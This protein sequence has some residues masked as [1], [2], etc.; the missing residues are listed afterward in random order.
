MP[1][2]EVGA[3]WPFVAGG[4]RFSQLPKHLNKNVDSIAGRISV[5]WK[6]PTAALEGITTGLLS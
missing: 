4:L 1:R 3:C 5:A 6:E 2:S